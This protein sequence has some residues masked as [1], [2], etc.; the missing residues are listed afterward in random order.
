MFCLHVPECLETGAKIS[1]E[2]PPTELTLV[3]PVI[4]INTHFYS[5]L[6]PSCYPKTYTQTSPVKK[7]FD[8][9][10]TFLIPGKVRLMGNKTAISG[11]MATLSCSYSL[12]ERVHQVLWRKTAEQ[13]DTTT[14][15][16]YSKKGHYNVE[17]HFKDHVG[18][19]RTLDDT[20]LT[21]RSVRTEDEACYTC[22]FHTYPDG[23]KRATACLSV[24]GESGVFLHSLI[25]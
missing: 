24:Y 19:S 16:S 6:A 8:A 18:L 7:S 11:K 3:L 15:A 25:I 22:E 2:S 20:Q 17:E 21:I 14:V 13:G 23:I 4:T 10:S 1:R 12:P 9:R 5:S